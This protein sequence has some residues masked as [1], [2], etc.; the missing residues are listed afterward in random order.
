MSSK[1]GNLRAAITA[2]RHLVGATP[3]HTD[4]PVFEKTSLERDV[5][6]AALLDNFFF[7]KLNKEQ[8]DKLTDAM[9]KRT[10]PKGAEVIQEEAEGIY[11]YILVAG[12]VK[13]MR[14]MEHVCNLHPGCLFGEM[15]LLYNCKRTASV[16]AIENITTWVFGHKVKY[17]MTDDS[18]A[19]NSDTF[20]SSL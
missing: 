6:K 3:K 4:L 1:L 7:R 11:M 9:E 10:Y 12:E 15:A 13:I 16:I 18:S 8:V 2:E 17:Y 20:L 14:G 5:I 19:M